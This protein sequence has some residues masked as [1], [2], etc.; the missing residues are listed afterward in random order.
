MVVGLLAA[1]S[2]D[3]ATIATNLSANGTYLL[4]T[5]RASVYSVEVTSSGTA[6]LNFY[7]CSSLAVPFY[8]TNY[9]NDVYTNRVTYPT[10]Y[11]YSF[12]GNNGFTNWYTNVGVWTLSVSNRANTNHL[13]AM[14]SAVVAGGTYA[15]YNTDAL[16][17]N[18]ITVE[19]TGTNVAVVVNYR[20]GGP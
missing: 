13:P 18:G 16:F 4:S 19:C 5:T 1:L 7:D 17:A 3:A 20:S 8:G 9:T 10:N 15:V 6:L 14:F 12:V 11:V 2:V